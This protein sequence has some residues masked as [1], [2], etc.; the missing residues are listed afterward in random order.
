M[1][2]FV[3]GRIWREPRTKVFDCDLRRS[4]AIYGTTAAQL[5]TDRHQ[6]PTKAS[7]SGKFTTDSHGGYKR[8]RS[9]S[10]VN[11]A[12]VLCYLYFVRIALHVHKFYP[13]FSLAWRQYRA[14]IQ[15]SFLLSGIRT[16]Y[17]CFSLYSTWPR[18][19][20]FIWHMTQVNYPYM[21]KVCT[22]NHYNNGDV[23]RW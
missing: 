23:V 14:N 18:S 22:E 6:Q 10:K 5:D 11:D 15:L 16:L 7:Q 3:F 2:F 12:V 21:A 1:F 13:K 20:I 17:Y 4:V 9:Q 8:L 19:L